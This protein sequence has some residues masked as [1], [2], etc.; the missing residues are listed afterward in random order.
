M[1]SA[2]EANKEFGKFNGGTAMLAV[3]GYDFADALGVREALLAGN[4]V[5]Q[6]EDTRNTFTRQLGDILSVNFKLE[7]DRWGIRTDLS[8]AAGYLTQSDLWGAMV[9][10]YLNVTDKFQ[11]IGRYTYLHS[12]DPNGVLLATYENRV[13]RGKG[14][15][16]NEGYLG[17]NYFFYG[18]KLKLQTG[19]QFADM[20][21]RAHDGGEYSGLA[22]TTGLRVGR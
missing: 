17:A 3:M 8:T 6:T 12:E 16:F 13:V 15:R 14:D 5:H 22:W 2:G 18:H 7:S 1:Y 9:M 10:P 20:H 4:Y 11:L 19:L 21:D